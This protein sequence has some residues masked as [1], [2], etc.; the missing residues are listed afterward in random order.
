MKT[1]PRP[2]RNI[3]WITFL[4]CFFHYLLKQLLL[5]ARAWDLLL[6]QAEREAAFHQLE[7]VTG[8]QKATSLP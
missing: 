8:G 1:P 2:K 7:G 5:L 4:I 6:L 3:I